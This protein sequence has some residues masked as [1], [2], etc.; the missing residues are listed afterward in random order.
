[1]SYKAPDGASV[2]TKTYGPGECFG[3]SGALGA[4]GPAAAATAGAATRR[5][6]A[7]ALE[8]VTLLRLPHRHLLLLMRD[9]SNAMSSF[10]NVLKQRA[11]LSKQQSY[12]I[13]KIQLR[14][15]EAHMHRTRPPAPPRE[16]FEED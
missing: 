12:S 14:D 16:A 7:T 15:E 9:D 5:N 4:A 13:D 6:T 10:S 11:L 1:M 2:P 8:P 3:A